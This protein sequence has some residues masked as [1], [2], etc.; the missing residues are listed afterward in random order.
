VVSKKF[1]KQ[2]VKFQFLSLPRSFCYYFLSCHSFS[3]KTYLLVLWEGEVFYLLLLWDLSWLCVYYPHYTAQKARL[4]SMSSI[5]PLQVHH[6]CKIYVCSMPC[7]EKCLV[8]KCY[9]REGVAGRVFH[10][11]SQE[12]QIRCRT[13]GVQNSLGKPSGHSFSCHGFQNTKGRCE[14]G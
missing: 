11:S 5:N 1:E 14:T 3:R 2:E 12:E 9:H 8:C 10:G 6:V 4:G 7:T 13:P